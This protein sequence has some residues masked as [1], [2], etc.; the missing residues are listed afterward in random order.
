MNSRKRTFDNLAEKFLPNFSPFV[1]QCLNMEKTT[2]C[3]YSNCSFGYLNFGSHK[4]AEIVSP[5]D[6]QSFG[7]YPKLIKKM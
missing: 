3:F 7:G 1:A 5:N 2:F 6:R 4:F